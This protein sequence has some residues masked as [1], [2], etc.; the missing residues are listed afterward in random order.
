MADFNTQIQI[1]NNKHI[2][3]TN[4]LQNIMNKSNFSNSK[5]NIMLALLQNNY[6]HK[7]FNVVSYVNNLYNTKFP[8]SNI[9]NK[10]F[11][12]IKQGRSLISNLVF[13]TKNMA[14]ISSRNLFHYYPYYTKKPYGT[15]LKQILFK[16][17]NKF[18]KNKI[19][20]FNQILK[21]N[22]MSKYNFGSFSKMQQLSK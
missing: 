14:V 18:N 2:I 22:H 20:M 8:L 4:K 11:I 12:N 13:S 1:S 6:D 17:S 15:G 21:L 16:K 9:K 10:L 5:K 3:I 7:L 19:S